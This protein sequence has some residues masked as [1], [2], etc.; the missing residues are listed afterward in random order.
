MDFE[1][2]AEQQR[3]QSVAREFAQEEV[4][5]IS[6]EADE[7]GEFPLHL[8]PRM[9]E[10][11]FMGA[12]IGP[13]YGGS[14][15]DYL[16]YAL[17]CEELGRVD[18]SVRGFLTV[19]AGLVAGCIQ[20]WGTEE[21][22]RRYL[23]RLASG[24]W[25][26][27]YALTEPNAGSDVAGMES[28][29]T[30]DGDDYL[31]NGEKIWITNGTSANLAIVFASIDPE[32]KHRGICAFLVETN[33]PG[34]HREPMPGQEL[35]HRASEHVRITVHGC[36]VPG[37]AMLGEPGQGF[38]V[39]MSGLDRGRLGVAAG[40][41]GVAQAC[42]DACVAYTKERRQFGQRIADFEMVQATL[43]DMAADVEAARLLVYKAAWTKDRGLPATK[44]T[45]IAK[46]FATEAAVRAASE[47]VL[48]HGNRGYSNEYPVER[49]YRDI[50]GLEIYEGTSHI[51]RIIIAR[52][53]VGREKRE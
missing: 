17:I 28:T 27:C 52:E 13:Q 49:Y 38:K 12:T 41:V 4:A 6:R 5:P 47:A 39:A 25:I 35:G 3:I 36:R 23:P 30:E 14:G 26:G 16:R 50:K 24:E 22:K 31:L 46:L 8:V 43:A 32:A 48:L 2:T 20:E 33:T 21:Q 51:Q 40:A 45:S 29:A 37:S 10:L 15:M 44:A 42:L 9:G 53:L 1:L 18:S 11:G 19:H 34:F 7:R